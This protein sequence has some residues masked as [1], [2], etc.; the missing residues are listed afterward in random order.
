MRYRRASYVAVAL[1][2]LIV[3][4]SSP[5]PVEIPGINATFVEGDVPVGAIAP[6]DAATRIMNRYEAL[7]P[8]APTSSTTAWRPAPDKARASN[9]EAQ[10]RVRCGC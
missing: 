6:D 4:C 5:E 3:S 2:A 9:L 7:S 10:A 8:R 1:V